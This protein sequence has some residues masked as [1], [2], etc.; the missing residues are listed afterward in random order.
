[1]INPVE[2]RYYHY[3]ALRRLANE[4]DHYSHGVLRSNYPVDHP[5]FYDAI[6]S[7]IASDMDP[8]CS[9][10]QLVITSLTLLSSK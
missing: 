4:A 2:S 7:T 3:C 6:L 5:D 1:M 8:P 10:G 9:T